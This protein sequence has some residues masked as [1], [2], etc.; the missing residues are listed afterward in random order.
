VGKV[1]LKRA[2]RDVLPLELLW[3][4]KKGFGAPV[5]HW[6]RGELGDAML[7]QLRRSAVHDLGVLDRERI[8]TLAAE[9]TAG[10]ADR[11]FQL[12]NLLNLSFWF[13]H[14]IAGDGA[15]PG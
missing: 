5:S 7:G 12:W 14:W 13:D 1:V 2:M 8:D 15:S 10:R 3:Q 4:P 9:H 6:F 11:S